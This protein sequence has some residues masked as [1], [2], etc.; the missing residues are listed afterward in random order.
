MDGGGVKSAGKFVA[1]LILRDLEHV[2]EGNL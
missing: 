2:D 1:C